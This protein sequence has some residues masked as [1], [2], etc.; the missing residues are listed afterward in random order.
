M[1]IVKAAGMGVLVSVGAVVLVSILGDLS[2]DGVIGGVLLGVV[3]AV[4]DYVRHR[5][6]GG[7][8]STRAG[9]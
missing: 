7:A 4:S 5:K 6:E 2:L 1:L 8:R 9:K 3:V